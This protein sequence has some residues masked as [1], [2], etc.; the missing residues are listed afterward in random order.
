MATYPN[1]RGE[2]SRADTDDLNV[3]CRIG[4]ELLG[5]NRWLALAE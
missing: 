1:G 5:A 3:T 2:R 4:C